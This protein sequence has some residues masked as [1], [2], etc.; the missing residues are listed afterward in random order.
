MILYKSK[1]F[2]SV[3]FFSCNVSNIN[4]LKCVSVSN[5]EY[6]I[7]PKIISINSNEPSFYPYSVNL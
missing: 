7:R 5:R 2:F 3:I 6:K 4:S 1:Y